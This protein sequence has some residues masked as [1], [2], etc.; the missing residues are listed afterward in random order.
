M[1]KLLVI[2]AMIV[3]AF[4]VA[5]MAGDVVMQFLGSFQGT[6]NMNF[7]NIGYTFSYSGD[8]DADDDGVHSPTNF[9]D[10]NAVA[11][12]IHAETRGPDTEFSIFTGSTDVVDN[13]WADPF[14]TRF[15]YW[16]HTN[17]GTDSYGGSYIQGFAGFSGGYTTVTTDTFDSWTGGGTSSCILRRY[18]SYGGWSNVGGKYKSSMIFEEP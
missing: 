15:E 11:N 18:G 6:W 4:G 10:L 14:T 8:T 2:G 17:A 12:H 3:L 16:F 9:W 5:G 1:R 7:S 13:L